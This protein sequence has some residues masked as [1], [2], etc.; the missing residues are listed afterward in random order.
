L[1]D[2]ALSPDDDELNTYSTVKSEGETL[3]VEKLFAQ[4][5]GKKAIL[6]CKASPRYDKNGTVMGA[7][8]SIRDITKRKQEEEK[9][10]HVNR[11]LNLLTRITRHD[12]LNQLM[13]LKVN[14]ELSSTHL[15]NPIRLNEFIEREMKAAK[16][17]EEQ[18]AFTQE[19]QDMGAKPPQ[20]QFLPA[21]I[22]QEKNKLHCGDIEI[23]TENINQDILA[24]SLFGKVIYNLA[25]NALKYGGATITKIQFFSYESDG[26][27][28]LVCQ[29]DRSGVI[30]KDKLRIFDRGFGKHTGLGLYLS[31]EILS[32]T[33]ITITEKGTPGKGARFEITVP[34][35]AWRSGGKSS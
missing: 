20:W 28:I 1:I 8:E 34:N 29:D 32:L 23:E 26:N 14:L 30:E 5:R 13:I 35:G 16:T 18:I 15:D 27:L 11:Q 4:P 9:F 21:I 2:L 6:W 7:V 19:F 25:D 3:V 24:D 10:R 17:I 31:R 12:I 22:E 33:G